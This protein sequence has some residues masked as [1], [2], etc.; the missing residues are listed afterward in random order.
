MELYGGIELGG[1][2][3]VCA[4]GRGPDEIAERARFPTTSPDETLGRTID[5]LRPFRGSLR[6]VGIGAFGPL[7]LDP[8]SATYG[9][10]TTTP[11]PGW[12]GAPVKGRIEDALGVPATIETDVSAA[13]VG[14]W[15]WGSAQAVETVAYVTVGTGIGAGLLVAGH[16]YRGLSHPEFGHV[17]VP[18]EPSDDFRG[19]CPFHGACLEGL[20]A[21]PAIASR[22]QTAPE[23]LPPDHPAWNLEAAYLGAGLAGLVLTLSP[24]RI[25]LGGGVMTVPV[26]LDRVRHRLREWL[27]GYLAVAPLDGPLDDYL[28]PPAL[29]PDAGVLGAI[30]L[31][32]VVAGGG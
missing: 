16:L 29:G 14:E 19:A 8:A 24:G 9:A 31:A 1:T 12:Q 11:K 25:V 2:K 26:L 17:P 10:L 20:A 7:D 15:R 5:F 4:V 27:G 18:R 21:G 30:A 28:V 3:V 13:A 23:L 6:A 32:Q 22:W